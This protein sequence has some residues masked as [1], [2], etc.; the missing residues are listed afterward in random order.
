MYGAG[1]VRVENVPD[2]VIQ[3][4]SDAIVRIV[5]SCV[6]G[7]DLH[8]YHGMPASK[9]GTP[10]GHEFIGVVEET[11]KEVSTLKKG[12]V[13]DCRPPAVTAGSGPPAES[14]AHRPRPSAYLSLTARWSRRRSVRTPHCCL[15]C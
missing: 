10:M 8:P 6:C 15:R 2:P 4:P 7:S 13:K 1:D 11:G 14:A 12:A 3:E 9:Q 5:R